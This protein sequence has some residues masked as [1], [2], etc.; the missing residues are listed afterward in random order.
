MKIMER[1]WNKKYVKIVSVVVVLFVLISIGWK[2][3]HHV[4]PEMETILEENKL[5]PESSGVNVFMVDVKG[6]VHSP[7]VYEANEGERVF[8]VIE[9]AGGMTEDADVSKVNLALRVTDE[10]VI[11]VP[12]I[13]GSM[14][15][16]ESSNRKINLNFAD[17][18]QLTQLPGIGAKKAEAII[19]YREEH[20]PFRSIDEIKNIS[21]IGEQT[22]EQIKELITAP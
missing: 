11:N 12:T 7:G 16:Q 20:G 5:K 21:G 1:H 8:H 13:W 4:P 14:E 2:Q 15:S 9:R 22:F 3:F 17:A 6:A 10:M 18:S 19:A